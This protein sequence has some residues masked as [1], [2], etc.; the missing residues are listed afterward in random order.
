LG[1][2]WIP[3]VVIE[4]SAKRFV[5]YGTADVSKALAQWS[6]WETDHAE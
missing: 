6:R 1:I 2:E 4:A 5:V 3:A